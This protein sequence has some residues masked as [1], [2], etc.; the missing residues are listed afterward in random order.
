MNFPLTASRSVLRR[1]G[2]I[3]TI[4]TLAIPA[5]ALADCTTY[6]NGVT[7]DQ[8]VITVP[9]SIDST[10]TTEVSAK[11]MQFLSTVPA[12]TAGRP[13]TIRF[14]AGGT[15]WSD[16]TLLLRNQGSGSFSQ[17]M[18]SS[19]TDSTINI[20]DFC[21]DH[22]RFDL[23]G[24]TIEQRTTVPFM[25]GGVVLDARKR[26]G[27][28]LISTQGATDVEIFGGTLLG[29]KNIGG[30]DQK[31]EEW[32]GVRLTG[33]Q[34]TDVVNHL[35]VRDM[36]INRV[37]GDFVYVASAKVPWLDG[38]GRQQFYPG[39]R[40]VEISTLTDVQIYNNVMR[41]AGRQ[42]IVLNGGSFVDIHHND[43]SDVNR[44]LFDSEPAASQGFSYVNIHHN[45][46]GSGGIGFF[47]FASGGKTM[48][49]HLTI[50]DNVLSRGHFDTTLQNGQFLA[51]GVTPNSPR[52]GFVMRNNQA[53]NLAGNTAF[54][55]TYNKVLLGVGMWDGV[56]I[57]G[58]SD[59][60][61]LNNKGVAIYSAFNGPTA[62]NVVRT[63]N[64]W[65]NFIEGC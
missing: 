3:T 42:G 13:V 17:T 49:D 4:A 14:A 31:F 29:S 19:K 34:D 5:T 61:K 43:F 2:L 15:Y 52:P 38:S 36:K 20:P 33:N 44:L 11:L 23:N 30:Y 47:Q 6:P 40:L 1:V 45:T 35:V 60:A 10:G 46:G 51:D 39:G 32:S 55:G 48:A 12:G 64:C 26:W 9:A 24:A 53:L 8:R 50:T 56:T 62:T 18:W 16:Y 54:G 7:S 21:L 25:S 59:Y 22:L 65:V 63:G 27:D 57:T 37:W 41:N 28:P 58:N